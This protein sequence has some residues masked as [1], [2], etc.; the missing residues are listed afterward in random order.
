MHILLID[1]DDLFRSSAC[2]HFKLLGHTAVD[3]ATGGEGC[4]QASLQKFDLIVVDMLMGDMDGIET[5][6][7]LRQLALD[8]PILAISGGGRI[9]DSGQPLYLARRLGADDILAK[10][11][12]FEA[13]LAQ[14][15]RLMVAGT[16]RTVS[17]RENGRA[18]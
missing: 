9:M 16:V 14:A 18:R 11:F 10:P 4:K 1:D 8:C 15:D 17:S 5:I 3:A 7:E 2:I 12:T 13:L 6:R